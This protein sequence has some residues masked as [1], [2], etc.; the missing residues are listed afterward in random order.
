MTPTDQ[1]FWGPGGKKKKEGSNH[2][3]ER[4]TLVKHNPR[5]NAKK[6]KRKAW[7]ESSRKRAHKYSGLPTKKKS[8]KRKNCRGVIP[9]PAER[10]MGEK[11]LREGSQ[12]SKSS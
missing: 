8:T 10:L 9:Q 1:E 4:E 7:R 3:F 5:A 6:K 12:K 11:S 2:P